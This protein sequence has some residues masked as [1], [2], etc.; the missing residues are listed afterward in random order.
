MF[1]DNAPS[2]SSKLTKTW[3]QECWPPLS[4]Q[5]EQL[6]PCSPDLTP[7]DF[8]LWD[9]LKS[10]LPAAA[11]GVLARKHQA[12]TVW[13]EMRNSE[14][15]KSVMANMGVTWMNRIQKCIEAEGDHFE[16]T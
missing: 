5:C 14:D 15:V 10:R 6:P 12:I 7:C 4:L 9:A 1:Q 2:H 3:V 11:E 16:G 13:A 8:Y